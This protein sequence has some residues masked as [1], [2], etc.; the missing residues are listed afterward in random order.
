MHVDTTFEGERI[1]LH[2]SNT[3]ARQ[4]A[5]PISHSPNTVRRLLPLDLSKGFKHMAGK[6]GLA[7]AG[8]CC[9]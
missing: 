7:C 3:A 6:K 1:I 8:R 9:E 4:A 5:A 2:Q